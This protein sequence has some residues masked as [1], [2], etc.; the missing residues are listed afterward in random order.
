MEFYCQKC[1]RPLKPGELRY[2]L[3]IDLIS[4]FD[5]H[6][7]EPEG[8]LDE[9]LDWLVESLRRQDPAEA[10]KDVAQTITLVICRRCRNQLVREWDVEEKKV[11]H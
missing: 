9:E 4:L 2:G 10:A 11:L 5:G 1:K 8:D 6:L 3:K 7:E